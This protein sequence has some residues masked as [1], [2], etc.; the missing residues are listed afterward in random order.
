MFACTQAF[1]DSTSDAIK[2]F[3]GAGQSGPFFEK[4]YGYAVFPNIG[5]G[6]IG[7]GGAH[8]KGKEFA[9]GKQGTHQ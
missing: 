7:I 4:C 8:G 1:A 9:G 6:G 3:R 5:K 2:V